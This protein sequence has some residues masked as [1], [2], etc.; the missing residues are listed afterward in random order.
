MNCLDKALH[1]GAKHLAEHLE[2]VTAWPVVHAKATP[3]EDQ[4][5]IIVVVGHSKARSLQGEIG[6]HGSHQGV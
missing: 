3:S 1:G 2:F 4:V 5:P 6:A